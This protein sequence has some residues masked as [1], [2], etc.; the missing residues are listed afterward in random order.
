MFFL[1]NSTFLKK[2]IPTFTVY[3]FLHTLSFWSIILATLILRWWWNCLIRDHLKCHFTKSGKIFI[4]FFALHLLCHCFVLLSSFLCFHFY[5][6]PSS[7][8]S[9]PPKSSHCFVHDCNIASVDNVFYMSLYCLG[10][11]PFLNCLF[12]LIFFC[13]EGWHCH[14]F[15]DGHLQ[16]ATHSSLHWTSQLEYIPGASFS[17]GL[18]GSQ[19]FLSY[20]MKIN[21]LFKFISPLKQSNV[22]L[23]EACWT[24]WGLQHT[25]RLSFSC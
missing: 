15:L 8:F 11:S 22:S 16:T 10:Y 6:A 3:I 7:H 13:R 19:R 25:F 20:S 1:S 18:K 23:N 2:K 17:T 4:L 14:L 12:F 9:L 5:V 24:V 21:H